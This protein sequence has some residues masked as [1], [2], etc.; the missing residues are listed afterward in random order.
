M[1]VLLG[2]HII[3]QVR[4]HAAEKG[5]KS[6]KQDDE[7]FRF[8]NYTPKHISVERQR[9]YCLGDRLVISISI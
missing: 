7:T 5:T 9:N 2:S 6:R 4:A 1:T 3:S 8:S